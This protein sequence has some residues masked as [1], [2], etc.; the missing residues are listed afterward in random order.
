MK[1]FKIWA[2]WVLGSLCTWPVEKL[3]ADYGIVMQAVLQCPLAL[4]H[5]SMEL[6]AHR[7][8]ASPRSSP[9]LLRARLRGQTYP[10][11]PAVLKI[12]RRINSLL[13]Y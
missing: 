9:A 1:F 3:K 12:I 4:R 6:K 8:L 11:D 10:M 2:L 13:P 7:H 5:A